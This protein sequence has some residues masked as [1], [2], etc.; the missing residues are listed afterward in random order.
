M[1]LLTIKWRLVLP[2]LSEKEVS[3]C[4][5]Y[6]FYQ[7]L[8]IFFLPTT[9]WIK[10]QFTVWTWS[11]QNCPNGRDGKGLSYQKYVG[12]NCIAKYFKTYRNY[13]CDQKRRK[14]YYIACRFD[15]VDHKK[16]KHIIIWLT[17]RSLTCCIACHQIVRTFALLCASF[18]LQSNKSICMEI[19]CTRHSDIREYIWDIY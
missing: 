18:H 2:S 19:W 11:M 1:L 15:K 4:I 12:T 7:I 17:K 3:G 6:F 10:M 14:C 13:A 8:K 5:S 9:W 16:Q